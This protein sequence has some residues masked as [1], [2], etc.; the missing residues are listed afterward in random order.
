M[1]LT[2][3]QNGLDAQDLSDPKPLFW[4]GAHPKPSPGLSDAGQSHSLTS[5][6]K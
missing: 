6:I 1:R 5:S 3:D 2:S 4:I